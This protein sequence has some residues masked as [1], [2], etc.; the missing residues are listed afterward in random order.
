ML[1]WAV[2]SRR[3]SRSRGPR[4]RPG[5]AAAVI[6][7]ATALCVVGCS[8][9]GFNGIYSIPL[10]G[11]A[12]LGSHPYQVTA[13]FTN[14]SDL[15]PQSAVKVNDVAVGRVSKIYLPPHS[16]IAHVTLLVNGGIRLPANAIAQLTSSSLLGEQYIALSAPP[17][18]PTVGRLR[19]GDVIPVSRTTSNA[20]VEEVFGALSLLL[21]GGGLAQLH[22]ITVEL[23]AAFSGNEPQIRALIGEP[24][25]LISNLSAHRQ[26]IVRALDGL[27]A[28]SATL[29]ARNNQIDHVLRHL[30]PGLQ[31]LN[32]QR[33]QLVTML[34]AL[35]N[36]SGVAV[37]TINAS[38]A[39]FVANL[40]A[41][42]P[43]LRELANAGNSLPLA[44]QVL[45][46]YPFSDQ[47]LKDIKGDYINAYLSLEAQKGTTV[48]APVSPRPTATPTPTPTPVKNAGGGH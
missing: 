25:T 44:L 22:T 18:I 27:N 40:R 32:E 28:L 45:L 16:W 19:N 46:T 39:A 37:H 26:D 2:R 7:V 20:T 48:I 1:F 30:T 21:N 13:E 24:A 6:A 47:V 17:G 34:N 42:E 23:N 35:N 5:I 12:S 11:G 36:L 10:P 8:S 31:V 4:R 33:A 15:V 3:S 14:V 43:T 29:A 41:L 9:G 38:Q